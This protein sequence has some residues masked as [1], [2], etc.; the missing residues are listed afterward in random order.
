M[1]PT[2]RIAFYDFDGTLASSNIVTRYA[3]LARRLPSRPEALWKFSRLVASV[4]AYLLL[5][6]IS[7]RFFNEVFFREYRGMKK[8]WLEEQAELLFD[9][10]IRPSIYAGAKGLLDADRDQGFYRILVTGELD[11]ALAPVMRYFELDQLISN[12]LVFKNGVATGEVVRPLIAEEQ[13]V[14]AMADVCRDHHADLRAARAYSDSFSDLPMLEAAGEPV[15]VNPDRRLRELALRRGW[16]ALDFKS[17]G[18]F[19][20]GMERGNHVHI[21]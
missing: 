12:S 7:R 5:D 14:R 16:P 2:P 18:A 4:P 15:A 21:S 3:F 17:G 9:E 10:V 19:R 20:S 8:A 13:K 6:R 11:F 1:S